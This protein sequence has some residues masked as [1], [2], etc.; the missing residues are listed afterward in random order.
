MR[1]MY[2]ALSG[3]NPITQCVPANR[4]E[5]HSFANDIATKKSIKKNI[6]N[7]PYHVNNFRFKTGNYWSTMN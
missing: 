4:N 7:I 3:I 5:T 6:K 1:N 2:V